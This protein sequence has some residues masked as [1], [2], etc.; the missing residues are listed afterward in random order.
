MK[1]AIWILGGVCAGI[2][3]LFMIGAFGDTGFGL[4]SQDTN[5]I[6][7]ASTSFSQHGYD[8]SMDLQLTKNGMFAITFILIGLALMIRA[9]ATA[10]LETD[11]EY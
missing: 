8:A 5:S 7:P 3:L 11:H 4:F 9:N 1:G 10:W 2:G 6:Q